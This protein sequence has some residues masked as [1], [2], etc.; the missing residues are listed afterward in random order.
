MRFVVL[1]P[2]ESKTK[3]KRINFGIGIF[4]VSGGLV[5][6]LSYSLSTVFPIITFSHKFTCCT[7]EM[8]FPSIFLCSLGSFWLLRFNWL[9]LKISQNIHSFFTVR[10]TF[11]ICHIKG[12]YSIVHTRRNSKNNKKRDWKWLC[13]PLQHNIHGAHTW[14]VRTRD[15]TMT[16]RRCHSSSV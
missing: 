2:N 8:A 6:F 9:H 14:F 5:R 16:Y 11:T 13:I 1:Y 3:E 15:E 12:H 4:E 10:L 7:L